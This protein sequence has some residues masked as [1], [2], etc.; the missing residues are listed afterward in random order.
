MEILTLSVAL[1]VQI[2]LVA[3]LPLLVRSSINRLPTPTRKWLWVAIL[4][5]LV[6][7]PVS[8]ISGS[9]FGANWTGL[10]WSTPVSR[11]PFAGETSVSGGQGPVETNPGT[12]FPGDAE[13]PMRP[14]PTSEARLAQNNE[15][16]RASHLTSIFRLGM[17]LWLAGAG[18]FI[19]K[20]VRGDRISR[21]IRK[22]SRPADDE[23]LTRLE[24]VRRLVGL[25]RSPRLG[26]SS[27]ILSPVCTG[28]FRPTILL[29]EAQRGRIG[30][31]T[32]TNFLIHECTH[33]AQRDPFLGF[34]QRLTVAAYWFHPLVRMV[35]R[36]LESASEDLCDDVVLSL[37]PDPSGGARAY[38]RDLLQVMS[39]A[40]ERQPEFLVHSALGGRSGFEQ[41]IRSLLR[42]DREPSTQLGWKPRLAIPLASA[43]ILAV[44][45]GC[46]VSVEESNSAVPTGKLRVLYVEAGPTWDYRYLKNVLHRNFDATTVL[47]S[48]SGA[49]SRD[50]SQENAPVAQFPQASASLEDY[51]VV[52][53]GDIDAW[54]F[55]VERDSCRKIHDHL[56]RFAQEGGGLLFKPGVTY[57]LS[58][59]SGTSLAPLV[60]VEPRP[61]PS[62]IRVDALFSEPDP[63]GLRIQLTDTGRSHPALRLDED[64]IVSRSQWEESREE[65]PLLCDL[66]NIEDLRALRPESQVLATLV[67]ANPR[68]SD[69]HSLE[70]SGLERP[71]HP[72]VFVASSYG[73]GNT[74]AFG[75]PQTWRLRGGGDPAQFEMLWTRAISWLA[76]KPH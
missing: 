39:W 29:P 9:F 42:E 31:S 8:L 56:V 72:P 35:S 60:P 20:L 57:G 15:S 33:L 12:G 16:G 68:D 24:G 37:S 65:M 52:L 50:A 55:A 62:R 38:A 43:C 28:V 71:P 61:N 7:L 23:F 75:I 21:R 36:E 66:T 5:L 3:A 74:L 6:S 2:T 64:F 27:Q 69:R 73:K 40:V 17:F 70:T 67:V 59:Y 53:L 47:L 76:S 10:R 46:R 32:L 22:E 48:L 45:A 14:R 13:S 44:L 19:A 1:V 58:T 25:K 11:I 30:D 18:F 63:A 26:W 54:S 41:R 51:D 49:S 34:L 4:V